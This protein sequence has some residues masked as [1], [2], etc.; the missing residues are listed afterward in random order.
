MKIIILILCLC[1]ACFTACSPGYVS[2]EPTALISVR[3]ANPGHNRVWR[4]GDWN[5]NRRRRVYV[6][7]EGYWAAPR[8]NRSYEA[9][10]WN[11]SSRGHSWQR[12]HWK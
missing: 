12:G 8:G 11:S 7:Q 3:P 6:Q 9:G 2:S 10:H 1:A 4:D 5:Y